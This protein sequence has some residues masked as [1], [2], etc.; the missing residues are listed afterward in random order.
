MALQFIYETVQEKGKFGNER[1]RLI[2]EPATKTHYVLKYI[3]GN[4]AHIQ[5][6]AKKIL[7]YVKIEF[8][9]FAPLY[10][11][12]VESDQI[13]VRMAYYPQTLTELTANKYRKCDRLAVLGRI[14]AAINI[15]EKEGI[16]HNKI[17][18]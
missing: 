8:A 16:G 17:E 10:Q 6:T 15:L 11:I 2:R 12:Q 5:A 1:V 4:Q 9:Y 7:S 13:L 18:P 14:A 3:I